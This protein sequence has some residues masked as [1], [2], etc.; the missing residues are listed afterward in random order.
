MGIECLV[1]NSVLERIQRYVYASGIAIR[2]VKDSFSKHY[3][4]RPELS[5]VYWRPIPKCLWLL[6]RRHEFYVS[7]GKTMKKCIT[8]Y[9]CIGNPKWSLSKFVLYR[10][11]CKFSNPGVPTMTFT[12][13]S[14][15]KENRPARLHHLCVYCLQGSCSVLMKLKH[16]VH[17]RNTLRQS[18]CMYACNNYR[19]ISK[20]INLIKMN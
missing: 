5:N 7:R 2:S 11:W 20:Y 17:Y 16:T 8:V 10:W 13:T 19:N 12:W 1:S 18:K 15:L 9:N 4:Y 6:M 3:G 14:R